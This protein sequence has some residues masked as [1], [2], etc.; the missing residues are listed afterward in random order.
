MPLFVQF[1]LIT[2]AFI[3]IADLLL[4]LITGGIK[5]NDGIGSVIFLAVWTALLAGVPLRTYDRK[6]ADAARSLG[7]HPR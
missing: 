1:I 2:V 7:V 5:R 4:E 3:F 6:L